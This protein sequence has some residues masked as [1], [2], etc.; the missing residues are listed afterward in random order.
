M[1]PRTLPA[2]AARRLRFVLSRSARGR[3]RAALRTRRSVV[4][5]T[6]RITVRDGAGNRV[7]STRAYG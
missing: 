6:V 2:G 5:A 7:V 4:K 3:L 1:R